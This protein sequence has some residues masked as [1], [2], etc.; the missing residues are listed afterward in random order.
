MLYLI[1]KSSQFCNIVNK[2]EEAITCVFGCMFP[3]STIS[4][5]PTCMANMHVRATLRKYRVLRY[6]IWFLEEK[7]SQQCLLGVL[8]A[9][10]SPV[11]CS[12]TIF[13]T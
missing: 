4:A 1:D 3:M 9:H 6:L 13:S 8:R 2:Y 5:V 7:C 12:E 10:F 11:N